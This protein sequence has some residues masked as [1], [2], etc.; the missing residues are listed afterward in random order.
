MMG[1]SIMGY[2]PLRGTTLG[3]RTTRLSKELRVRGLKP[4]TDLV[5][6]RFIRPISKRLTTLIEG[7]PAIVGEG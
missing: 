6:K 5:G 2:G 3:P 4:I 1:W 7:L